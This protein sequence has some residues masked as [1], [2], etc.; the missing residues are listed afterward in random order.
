MRLGRKVIVRPRCDKCGERIYRSH[1][2]FSNYWWGKI[3]SHCPNCGAE[4]KM[5]KKEHFIEHESLICLVLCTFFIIFSIVT[6]AII[7]YFS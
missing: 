1:S 7:S 6:L 5:E 2:P 3:P 4:I